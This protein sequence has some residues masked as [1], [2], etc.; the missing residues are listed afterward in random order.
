[1]HRDQPV[2]AVDHPLHV[3]AHPRVALHVRVERRDRPV[4]PGRRIG[5][6]LDVVGVHPLAERLDQAVLVVEHLDELVRDLA[7]GELR[8]VH[9][10]IPFVFFEVAGSGTSWITSQCSRM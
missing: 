2:L 6:V 3:V 9:Q 4:T 10:N 1:M 7:S 5:V 8:A